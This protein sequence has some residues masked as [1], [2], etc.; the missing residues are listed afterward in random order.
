[1]K[2]TIIFRV[3]FPL[4]VTAPEDMV[5]L[6]V[7]NLDGGISCGFCGLLSDGEL[8]MADIGAGRDGLDV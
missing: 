3:D 1:M 8:G 6:Y 5:L 2:S 7:V 4:E